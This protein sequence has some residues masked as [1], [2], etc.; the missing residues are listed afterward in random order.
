MGIK[1]VPR[2]HTLLTILLKLVDDRFRDI[3][4]HLSFVITLFKSALIESIVIFAVCTSALYWQNTE[5]N[6][7]E[8]YQCTVNS[9][10]LA[11]G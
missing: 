5:Q 6:N 3:T 11:I 10:I 7:S 8:S 1:I 2:P 9:L 4:M